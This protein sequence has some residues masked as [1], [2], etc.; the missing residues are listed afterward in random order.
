[1]PPSTCVFYLLAGTQSKHTCEQCSGVKAAEGNY[2]GIPIWN[3]T[4]HVFDWQCASNGL[5]Q[6]TWC[7]ARQTIKIRKGTER[8]YVACQ[9]MHHP[10]AQSPGHA[11]A[12]SCQ[13][14]HKHYNLVVQR[15]QPHVLPLRAH[16]FG[17]NIPRTSEVSPSKFC[18]LISLQSP[19]RE[20]TI[21]IPRSR[22]PY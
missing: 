15:H 8:G 18:T 1:M 21:F 16:L 22:Q 13:I 2:T 9:R 7:N 6:T 20:C 11:L 19:F 5:K 12:C 4:L 17:S 14:E 10:S 3:K